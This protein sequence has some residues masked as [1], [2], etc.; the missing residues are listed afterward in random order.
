MTLLATDGLVVIDKPAGMTSHD[1]VAKLRKVLGTRRVGHG[2]TLDPMATG[3]LIIGVNAGTKALQFISGADKTYAATIV[4]GAT[5]V[6]DDADGDVVSETDASALQDDDIRNALKTFV[7]AIEQ[8]P[9][10]VSAIKIDGVRAHARVR[11]GEEVDIPART[12]NVY[13]IEVGDIR[14][15]DKTIEVDIEV[16][17]GTGT[18]IR[19]IARDLG[20]ILG[21]GGFLNA[22]RRTES[23]GFSIADACDYEVADQH[24]IELGQALSRFMPTI[25]VSPDQ[26]AR[27]ATGQRLVWQWGEE[28]GPFVV[29]D[30]E[31]KVVAIGHRD[32]FNKREVLGY[33]SVFVQP[34]AG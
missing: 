31:D 1:V 16:S 4:L 8:K 32:V 30:R 34:L 2:G 22:L 29:K 11:A 27:I 10:A 3:L 5:T 7:G 13:S 33:H 14:H 24:V 15:L 26:V 21:V 18:Y 12:V 20:E 23:S 9:S 17:C 6:S 25:T 19:A 28:L